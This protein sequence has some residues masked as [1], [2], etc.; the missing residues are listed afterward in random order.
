[1]DSSSFPLSKTQTL[2]NRISISLQKTLATHQKWR[3]TEIMALVGKLLK[4]RETL[5]KGYAHALQNGASEHTSTVLLLRK[6]N[7][8]QILKKFVDFF[9]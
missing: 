2:Q 4:N 5:K 3:P 9:S 7:L 1:M 8:A 6:G